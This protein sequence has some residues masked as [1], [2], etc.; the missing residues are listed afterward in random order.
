ME[1]II[2]IGLQGSGKSTFFSLKF[3]ETHLR[4]SLDVVRTRK[5][6]EAIVKAAISVGQRIV[7]DNTNPSPIDRARYI[8]WARAA[9]YRIVGYYFCSELEPCITRNKQ[10]YGRKR[11]PEKGLLGTYNKLKIPSFDEGF[12]ELYYVSVSENGFKV[13]EWRDEV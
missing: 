13:E 10:R 12:N 2:L 4:V 9:K 8:N 3:Q 5:R 11:I 7:I 6:E 1:L